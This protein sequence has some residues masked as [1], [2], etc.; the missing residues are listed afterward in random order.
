MLRGVEDGNRPLQVLVQRRGAARLVVD[1]LRGKDREE[2]TWGYQK[3]A[4]YSSEMKKL[5][6][7][8]GLAWVDYPEIVTLPSNSTVP[9][10]KLPC[11]DPMVSPWVGNAESVTLT[12]PESV[13]R[14]A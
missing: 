5:Y 12:M 4:P 10:A 11:A 7:D 8:R 3:Q 6:E 9:G 1:L 13:R 14:S 2:A